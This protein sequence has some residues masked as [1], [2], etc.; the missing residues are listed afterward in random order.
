MELSIPAGVSVTRGGGL[1]TRALSVVPLQQM[2]PRR[3]MST[4]SPYS[5]P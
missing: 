5:M 3:S 2:A 4:T 1:P